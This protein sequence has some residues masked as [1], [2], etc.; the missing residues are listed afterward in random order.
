MKNLFDIALG[1]LAAW[2]FISV[3]GALA[4]ILVHNVVERNG[5]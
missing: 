5:K 2:T 1:F 3:L 4:Y